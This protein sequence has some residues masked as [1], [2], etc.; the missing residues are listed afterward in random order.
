MS[1]DDL[2]TYT[3]YSSCEPCAMCAGAIYWSGIGGVVY[4]LSEAG[5]LEATGNADGDM[6]MHP[7]RAVFADGRRAIAV[8]G[9]LLEDEAALPHR[10]FWVQRYG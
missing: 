4:A 1:H 5:L 3:L 7:C 2:A 9:P 8:T 6:L 10:G